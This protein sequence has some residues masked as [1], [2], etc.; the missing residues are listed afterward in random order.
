MSKILGITTNVKTSGLYVDYNRGNT[1]ANLRLKSP[2]PNEMKELVS[3]LTDG[4]LLVAMQ[5]RGQQRYWRA[6][7]IK[8]IA[9]NSSPG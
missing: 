7:K 2:K 6:R 8:S 3:K 4:S 9:K 1:T 5:R